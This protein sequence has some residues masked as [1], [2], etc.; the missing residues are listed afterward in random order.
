MAQ[1][2]GSQMSSK[3]TVFLSVS[4]GGSAERAQSIART[5]ASDL[6]RGGIQAE[7]SYHQGSPGTRGDALSVGQLV[8][9]FLTGGAATALIECLRAYLTRDDTLSI[10]LSTNDGKKI[11]INSKNVSSADTEKVIR[12]LQ[13]L[14][15]G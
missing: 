8:L 13:D 1:G 7:E 11:T 4:A 9:A 10:D 12:S 2:G 3:S 14:T 6:R 15:K 5:L